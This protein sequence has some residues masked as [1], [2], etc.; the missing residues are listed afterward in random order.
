L[1]RNDPLVYRRRRRLACRERDRQACEVRFC[2]SSDAYK[3]VRTGDSFGVALSR[4]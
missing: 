3:L 1:D 4:A 2:S